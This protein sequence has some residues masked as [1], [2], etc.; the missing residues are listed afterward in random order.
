MRANQIDWRDFGVRAIELCE[1]F[2]TARW[3]PELAAETLRDPEWR[4]A[5][6]PALLA[7]LA[8]DLECG[9][10]HQ[11]NI[12]DRL[13]EIGIECGGEVPGYGYDPNEAARLVAIQRKFRELWSKRCAPTTTT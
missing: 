5:A 7:E 11:G 1:K 3:V 12:C 4:E 10:A 9:E 13:E 6:D 8:R 2:L